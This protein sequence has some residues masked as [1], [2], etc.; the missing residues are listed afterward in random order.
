MLSLFPPAVHSTGLLSP[1]IYWSTPYR[2][3]RPV[4]T[5]STSVSNCSTPAAP[6]AHKAGLLSPCIHLRY[7]ILACNLPVST[8][9]T[10]GRPAISLYSTFGKHVISLYL[11]AVHQAGLLS[12]YIHLQ[13]TLLAYYLPVSVCNT[14]YWSLSPCIHLR[15]TILASYLLVYT[16]G[17][18]YWPAISLYPPTALQA[19][20]AISV[21]PPAAQQAGL[22]SPFN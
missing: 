16:F 2:T 3:A 4:S 1:C 22:L 11:P 7:T 15:Y 21:Y 9:N 6:A 13:Y 17:A 8:C 18:P 5:C 14:P 10:P 19:G 20:L 12:I